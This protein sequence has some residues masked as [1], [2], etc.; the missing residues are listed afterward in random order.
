MQLGGIRISFRH[1]VNYRILFA[2]PSVLSGCIF[3]HP[4]P[5]LSI[6]VV[7]AKYN[8]EYFEHFV[9]KELQ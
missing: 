2:T 8:L 4:I 9:P 6:S 5:F 3:S 7:H 1:A